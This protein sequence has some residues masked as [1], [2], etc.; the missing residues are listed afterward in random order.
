MNILDSTLAKLDNDLNKAKLLVSF[1]EYVIS[2][3]KQAGILYHFTTLANIESII[4]D[5]KI[6]KGKQNYVSLTR[7]F[8]LP[9]DI[10]YFVESEYIVRISIDGNKLSE[11]VKII[12]HADKDY[13]NEKEEGILNNIDTKYFLRIDFI[14]DYTYFSQTAIESVAEKVKKDSRLPV[15]IFK[16]WVSYNRIK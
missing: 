2:E 10:N 12:P 8:Q 7:D 3:A 11:N 9:Y 16:K 13:P 1:K 14:R 6:K 5:K 4:K 15:Q